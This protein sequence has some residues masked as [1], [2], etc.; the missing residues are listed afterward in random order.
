MVD[1]RVEG[2]VFVPQVPFSRLHIVVAMV[3]LNEALELTIHNGAMRQ[4]AF[5]TWESPIRVIG[6]Y[7][8]RTNS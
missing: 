8:I 6:C 2:H 5:L 3:G 1:D 7:M 4:G